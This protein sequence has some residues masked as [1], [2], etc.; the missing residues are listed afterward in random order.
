MNHQPGNGWE[1]EKEDDG[2]RRVK[3]NRL[4]REEGAIGKNNTSPFAKRREV[5]KR[6]KKRVFG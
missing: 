1:D 6:R 4:G 3:K 5:G 2:N